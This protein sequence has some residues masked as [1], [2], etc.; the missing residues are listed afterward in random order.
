MSS[1]FT[2][3]IIAA[4]A[5]GVIAAVIYAF[6][7]DAQ[8]ERI[9]TAKV[10]MLKQSLP[11]SQSYHDAAAEVDATLEGIVGT[12]YEVEDAYRRNYISVSGDRNG[13]YGTNSIGPP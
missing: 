8:N 11:A 10:L 5:L 12:S 9:K 4:A 7:R 1:L 3:A 2:Y 6:K 13:F